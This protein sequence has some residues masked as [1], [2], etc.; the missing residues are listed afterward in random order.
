MKL[1]FANG[2]S[3]PDRATLLRAADAG[4]GEAE[5]W[6]LLAFAADESLLTD[7][8]AGADA[9]ADELGFSR[10]ELDRALGFLT[11]AG[12]LCRE[13]SRRKKKAETA[14]EQSVKADEKKIAARAAVTEL[15]QYTSDEFASLME[16]RAELRVLIDEAQNALGKTFNQSE[17]RQLV[18]ISEGLSVSAEYILLL[19]AYCRKVDKK[20]VRYAEKLAIGLYDDGVTTYEALT[21]RLRQLELADT[22]EGQIKRLFGFSRT[23]TAK[24]KS[25]VAAWTGQYG[26][27]AD[28]LEKAYEV[29][30]QA[31]TNPGLAYLHSILTRW[32]EE[33]IQT[34]ADADRDREGRKPPEKAQS[35]VTAQKP[36]PK[37]TSFDVDD[38]FAAALK[39]GYGDKKNG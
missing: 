31:T 38:F 26:F 34:P 32:H 3:V 15:P 9:L 35:A 24:E 2:R 6:L 25:M 29:A 22:A 8:D 27:D 11:G 20:S 13:N 30:V 39:K 36:A 16:H 5:L 17:I 1:S 37:A 33:G 18:A 14:A 12:I 23:L 7:F 28:M 4:A 21:E 10:A 19:I